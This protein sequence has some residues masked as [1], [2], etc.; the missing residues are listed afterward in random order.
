MLRLA[1]SSIN[2]LVEMDLDIRDL[3]ITHPP[4]IPCWVSILSVVG[5][6]PCTTPYILTSHKVRHRQVICPPYPTPIHAV[7]RRLFVYINLA[8]LPMLT[9][10]G[11]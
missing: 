4:K 5:S 10:V 6:F 11:G 7:I 3:I 2:H 9:T 8:Y 1:T